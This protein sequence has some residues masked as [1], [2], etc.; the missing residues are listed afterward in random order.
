MT[1][2]SRTEQDSWTPDTATEE[3]QPTADAQT[4]VEDIDFSGEPDENAPVVEAVA[5]EPDPVDAGIGKADAKAIDA[6]REARL[7][8]KATATLQ[9][10]RDDLLKLRYWRGGFHWWTGS[11]YREEST[12]DV[13][14]QLVGY[15]DGGFYRLTKTAVGNV[16]LCLE[17]ETNV[18]SHREMPSWFDGRTGGNWLAT[19]NGILNISALLRGESDILIPHSPRYFAANCLPFEFNLAAECP[20]WLAFLARNLEDDQERIALLQQFYGYCLSPSLTA[21]KFLFLEGEGANGKSVACAVLTAMLGSENVSS[22]PLEQFGERFGLYSTIGKMANVASEIGEI[23]RVAEGILK[24]YTTGDAI[25]FDRKHRDPITARPTAKLIF[26]S[27]NRPRF[28]D[29]S[30]G[31]WRRM[32]LMPWR[33]VIPEAERIRGMDSPQWWQEQGELP[34]ILLWA[35]AGLWQLEQQGG[36]CKSSVC[37]AALAEYRAESNPARLFLEEQ[38]QFDPESWVVC[39]DAYRPYVEWV[40]TNGFLPLSA[41]TFGHEVR[42]AFPLVERRMKLAGGERFYA[43]FGLSKV[44]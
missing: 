29:K 30:G 33:I 22:V 35:I 43:Y 37:E 39:E 34:G 32:I 23:N 17:A 31:L 9:E 8:L 5:E 3:C 2:E 11:H 28:S 38:F 27:N 14:A 18:G 40:K 41:S 1:T 13:R 4:A 24:A 6:M 44:T 36:F 25:Q 10:G 20:R 7:L 19:E 21:H 42:R 12:D 26:A 15:L 16:M